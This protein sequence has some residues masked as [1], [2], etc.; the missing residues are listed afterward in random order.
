MRAQ[1]HF[2]NSGATAIGRVIALGA[3]LAAFIVA[4]AARAQ[5]PIP[6]TTQFDYV[7]FIQEATLDP[8]CHDDPHC[9]GTIKVNGHVVVIPKETVVEFPANNL[10]WQELFA[11][12]PLPYGLATVPPSSGL[13]L[14]DLPAPLTTYEAHVIGNRVLGGAAGADLQIAGLIYISQQSLNSGAGFINFIDYALGEMRVGGVINDPNCAQGGTALTNPLC[15]GARVRIND[16]AGRYGRVNSPD[17]RFTVDP[18][19]P[20]IIAGSGYPMCLPRTDPAVA[21]DAL[22]P[23]AQRPVVSPGPPVVFQASIQTNDPVA[24][25]GV[26]PDA[27]FQVPFE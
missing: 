19:N 25:P 17:I 14:A 16:P 9:G 18:D 22:C 4:G 8:T 12:A 27:N 10:T 5:L 2:P 21:D 3:A 23:Q 1:N 11:Q 26:P 20:T 6:A 13:A 7:G 24:L 15:S